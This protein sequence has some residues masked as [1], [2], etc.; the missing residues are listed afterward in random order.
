MPATAGHDPG[1]IISDLALTIALGGDCLADAAVL[2]AQPEL[3]GPVASDP[4]ISRLLAAFAA[5]GPRSLRAIRK[6]RVAAR[7]RAWALAGESAPR[8]RTGA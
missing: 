1:K 4:V 3:A 2:R 6:A 5:Q 8:E 7:E